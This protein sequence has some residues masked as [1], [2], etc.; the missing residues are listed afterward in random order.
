MKY[1]HCLQ[2]CLCVVLLALI[3]FP[4][5][6]LAA[7]ENVLESAP[8]VSLPEKEISE[9]LNTED[10]KDYLPS[11]WNNTVKGSSSEAKHYTPWLT[12]S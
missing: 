9:T 12:A 1:M 8:V 2:K 11:F 7:V 5:S 3:V 4:F 6:A 10:S